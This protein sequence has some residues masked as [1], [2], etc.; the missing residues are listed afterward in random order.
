MD[1]TTTTC[2]PWTFGLGPICARSISTGFAFATDAHMRM[3]V[4]S[5]RMYV[6]SAKLWAGNTDAPIVG[7]A[8]A[9]GSH[10]AVQAA[11]GTR[12]RGTPL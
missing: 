4:P 7:A 12:P 5:V 11:A 3:D 6:P 8:V 10:K 9:N 1:T 2:T